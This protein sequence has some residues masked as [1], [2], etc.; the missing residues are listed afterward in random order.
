LPAEASGFSADIAEKLRVSWMMEIVTEDEPVLLLA[1]LVEVLV[2]L[3]LLLL[4]QAAAARTKASGATTAAPFLASWI[5]DYH[6]A[7]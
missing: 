6:L 1:E 7:S 3:L 2:V 4:L 5:M